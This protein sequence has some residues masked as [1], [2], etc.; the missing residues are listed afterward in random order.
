MRRLRGRNYE[1]EREEE[2]GD[3]GSTIFA[4]RNKVGWNKKRGGWQ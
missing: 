3:G 2:C 1:G 4:L